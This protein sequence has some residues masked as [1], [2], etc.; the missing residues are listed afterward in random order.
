MC[1]VRDPRRPRRPAHLHPKSQQQHQPPGQAPP[2]LRPHCHR[3]PPARPRRRRPRPAPSRR[4]GLLAPARPPSARRGSGSGRGGG[5]AG[6][7]ERSA[8][9]RGSGR[10]ACRGGRAPAARSG[11]HPA[12]TEATVKAAGP[13]LGS[14]RPRSR[15]RS[16]QVRNETDSSLAHSSPAY[17]HMHEGAGPR[18]GVGPGGSWGAPGFKGGG[19]RRLPAPRPGVRLPGRPGGGGTGPWGQRG[20]L[21]PRSHLRVSRRGGCRRR[22]EASLPPPGLPPGVRNRGWGAPRL[23]CGPLPSVRHRRAP[24][25]PR[26]DAASCCDQGSAPTRGGAALGPQ[27]CPAPTARPP[28][29]PGISPAPLRSCRLHA[30]CR[31][32][33]APPTPLPS[34][35]RG[36]P[37]M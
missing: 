1:P 5:G 32:R 27:P 36:A 13:G 9:A 23:P 22:K 20:P 16:Q 2:A 25:S 17:L 8:A 6:G 33:C 35:L 37:V 29:P 18:R 10:R 19:G 26:G 4:A 34:P 7:V 31:G 28:P 12:A 21:G 14:A 15:H 11:S 3:D 30:G 24:R